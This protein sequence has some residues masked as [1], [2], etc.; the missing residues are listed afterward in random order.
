MRPS[1]QARLP[2]APSSAV[3]ELLEEYRRYLEQARYREV[4]GRLRAAAACWQVMA[5]SSKPVAPEVFAAY[6]EGLGKSQAERLVAFERYLCASGWLVEARADPVARLVTALP[7]PTASQ[8]GRYLREM[9]RHN[10]AAGTIRRRAWVIVR[11]LKRCEPAVQADLRRLDRAQVELMIEVAQD[12]GQKPTTINTQL[13]DLDQFLTY[14]E[15]EGELSA[16]PILARHRLVEP[17]ALP[18][19]MGTDELRRLLSVIED[20]QDRAIYLT[21]LRSGIRGGE[22]VG[23]RVGDV[24]LEKQSLHIGHGSA[25]L[26]KARVVYFSEDAAAALRA[27]LKERGEVP[28]DRLFFCWPRLTLTR[29]TITWRFQR[30][31]RLA[32]I[33]APYTAHS[34]RHTFAT[35]LLNA[36]VSLVSVQELLGHE[37]ITT[38]Q[39][40]ARLSGV[41]KQAEYVAAMAGIEER[42]RLV[43]AVAEGVSR[44]AA[45]VTAS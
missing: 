7:E 23:L 30:Y 28:T 2:Q 4:A 40:Y 41:V 38:T 34:L 9:R 14:L 43:G 6:R 18:R 27:W 42:Q 37:R 22:L 44:D 13:A 33:V 1:H 17:E 20:V 19:A 15:R 36:G 35:Q 11:W 16:S 31:R 24:D 12:R 21:L 3:A 32:G 10:L 26:A 5:P 39:L 25:K 45:S 8:L 29:G